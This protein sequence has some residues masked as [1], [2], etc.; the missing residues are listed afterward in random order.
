MRVLTIKVEEPK[1]VARRLL[2]T[3]GRATHGKPIEG[4]NTLTFTSV[5]KLFKTL[6]PA[7]WEIVKALQTKEF[8]SIRELARYLKKDYANVWRDLQ[9][10]NDLGIVEIEKT[11]K[12][13]RVYVPYD[14]VVLEFPKTV[15]V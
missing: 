6:T 15:E 8:Q 2:K 7:R 14:R 1:K 12:G 5:E 13:H 4:E 10:L 3:L 11:D 9:I